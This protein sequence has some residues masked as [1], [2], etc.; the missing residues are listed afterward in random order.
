MQR[1]FAGTLWDDRDNYERYDPLAYAKEFQTPHF[2][3]HS[4]KDYRLPVSEGVMLFN[5]LQER[6]VDSRFLNY[7]DEGHW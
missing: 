3:V 1:D 5:V 6:G 2:V 7:P 4:S